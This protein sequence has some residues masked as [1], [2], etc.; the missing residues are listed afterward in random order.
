MRLSHIKTAQRESDQKR[1]KEREKAR[2]AYSCVKCQTTKD[3]IAYHNQREAIVPFLMGEEDTCWVA[4]RHSGEEEGGTGVVWTK[5]LVEI[6]SGLVEWE[7]RFRNN[8]TKRIQMAYLYMPFSGRFYEKRLTV[9][10]VNI[11]ACVAPAGFEPV[12]D[13]ASAMHNQL[14]HTGP[15]CMLL[16]QHTC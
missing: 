14:S 10:R 13:V 12:S 5:I 8:K 9:V 1:D 6:R 3:I 11:F 2:G 15:Y 16:R 7:I 4:G